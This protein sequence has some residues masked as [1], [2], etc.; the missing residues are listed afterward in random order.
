[1]QTSKNQLH[2]R[3]MY[4]V[5]LRNAFDLQTEY[6]RQE[7]SI[8]KLTEN[9]CLLLFSIFFILFLRKSYLGRRPSVLCLVRE[10]IV[11]ALQWR[12]KLVTFMH[13]CFLCVFRKNTRIGGCEDIERINANIKTRNEFTQ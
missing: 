7:C 11:N 2:L 6:L 1:M 4:I 9:I 13:F 8:K 5:H 10:I 12:D 3:R